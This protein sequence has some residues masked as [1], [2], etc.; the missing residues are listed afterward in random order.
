MDVQQA[1]ESLNYFAI[2]VA[3]LSAF[4]IGGLWY[5][6]L[7]VKPWM[8]ENGFNEEELSKSNMGKIFGGSFILSLIISFVLALF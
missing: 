8:K 5:S 2:L 7:F 3:A 4:L 1:I 6:L